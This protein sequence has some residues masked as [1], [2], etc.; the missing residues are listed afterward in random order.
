MSVP[1]STVAFGRTSETLTV[2]GRAGRFLRATEVLTGSFSSFLKY[3]MFIP[4]RGQVF[5]AIAGSASFPV[6]PT[7]EL[8]SNYI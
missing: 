7:G 2:R 4:A 1:I 3:S 6:S 8:L 5:P